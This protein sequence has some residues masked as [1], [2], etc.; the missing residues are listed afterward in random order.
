MLQN[1]CSFFT[2]IKALS[3]V[4]LNNK[5]LPIVNPKT[6]QTQLENVFC[7]GDF[8]G[9]AET[10]VE[11]VNDG[12]I[13]AWHIHCYLQ[14][15]PMDT[16]PELPLF[17]TD[18]DLVDISVEMC[19]I[20]F[21]NPFG[22]ASAPPTTSTAMIRR[23]FEQGW[24]FAV[25]KTFALDKDMVTNVSPRIVRGVTAGHNY[26]PQQGAFLNI[27]LIS[28]K[29]AEYWLQG[30]R[31][32]KQDFPTKVVVASIM[33]SYN[34][35]DWVQLAKLAE[36]AGSDA[37]EL[38]LSCPHGMGESGMGLACGQDPTLVYNI[39]LWVR[40]T[41]KIPFFIKLTPNITDI[42]SIAQAAYKGKADGVSAINTV[43]G[44]MSIKADT[45]PWPAVGGEQ[46]RTTY[47]GV[48]GN[49]TRPQALRA[50]SSIGNKLPGFP[51]MGIGGVDSADVAL[52]FLQCGASVLQ[53]CSSIQ[54][55]DF[56]VIEDYIT[57]LKAL[58]YLKAN[59]PPE[60]LAWE[61]QSPPTT[62]LQKGKPVMTLKNEDGTVSNKNYVDLGQ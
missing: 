56:T 6:Q 26:G 43:Q 25:T 48:S 17:Y 27:E 60:S 41:V 44:L 18:V 14:G 49:A 1:F 52:Q 57:G 22:L 38:N 16:P 9:N 40:D 19:G 35:D 8:A 46:K 55:Q 15:L 5:N 30:I 3:P 50:I 47:G 13:A 61:G 59:P 31:E 42:V 4:P 53:I 39:S 62:K 37:L 10:T 45:S 21:E 34:K 20:K 23:A 2:A 24:G 29:C 32:L 51:I 11:S 33:C 36:E 54:N 12:K 28:E 7:G 58:L